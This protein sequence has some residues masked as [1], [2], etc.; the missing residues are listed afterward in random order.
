MS[1]KTKITTVEEARALP[2][3]RS[4]LAANNGLPRRLSGMPLHGDSIAIFTDADGRS[5]RVVHTAE[6]GWCKVEHVL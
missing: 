5:M 3:I 1:E 4:L 6:Q 2:E